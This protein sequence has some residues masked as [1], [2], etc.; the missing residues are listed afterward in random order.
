[1]RCSRT[2]RAAP[3]E[4]VTRTTNASGVA[5]FSGVSV[6]KAGGYRLT[7][8]GSFDGVVGQPVTSN[9]FNIKNK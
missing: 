8:T 4:T 9:L 1:M 5:D 3:S 7:A 6:T 2:A